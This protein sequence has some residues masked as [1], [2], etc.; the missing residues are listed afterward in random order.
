MGKEMDVLDIWKER[1]KNEARHGD[2]K[3]AC[4]AAGTTATTF[5]T[6][7]KREKFID[8]KDGDISVPL[9]SGRINN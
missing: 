1:I 3:K 4:E 6:A 7:M 2:K 5:L 9:K 8:L